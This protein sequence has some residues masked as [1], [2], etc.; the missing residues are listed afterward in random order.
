MVKPILP[1]IQRWLIRRT[2]NQKGWICFAISF[3]GTY[4]IY[5]VIKSGFSLLYIIPSLFLAKSYIYW[6]EPP[7]R[8]IRPIFKKILFVMFILWLILLMI[9]L[10]LRFT[11]TI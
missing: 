6:I 5:F 2:D 3:V 10:I 4:L 9:E 11:G 8:K 1:R 7:Q